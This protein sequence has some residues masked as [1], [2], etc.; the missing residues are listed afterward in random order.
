MEVFK[1]DAEENGD[2]NKFSE[3]SEIWWFLEGYF[4]LLSLVCRS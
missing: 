2:G 1:G 3:F 4:H